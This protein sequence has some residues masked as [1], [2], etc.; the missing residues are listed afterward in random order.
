MNQI[1][2]IVFNDVLSQL[3]K[4][5]LVK[6]IDQAM[7]AY[8]VEH[9]LLVVRILHD[10]DYELFTAVFV[11]CLQ[12]RIAQII[13]QQILLNLTAKALCFKNLIDDG[14]AFSFVGEEEYQL[15]SRWEFDGYGV[16]WDALAEL[17]R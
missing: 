15:D 8:L 13:E 10:L 9:V 7:Q 11:Y 17:V 6:R 1:S 3:L 14:L 4:P 12:R 5:F 2:E 16:D